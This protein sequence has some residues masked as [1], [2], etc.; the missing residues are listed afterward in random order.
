MS[1]LRS[2]GQ[3]AYLRALSFIKKRLTPRLASLS[4]EQCDKA[5]RA[6]DV[7]SLFCPRTVISATVG[8]DEH[9]SPGGMDLSERNVGIQLRQ[10]IGPS[11]RILIKEDIAL[12]T[13]GRERL[14]GDEAFVAYHG[15][16]CAGNFK[17]RSAQVHS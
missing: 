11:E 17:P 5:T 10:S 9:P 7:L 1:H 12:L 13:A 15:R 2:G 6:F 14:F 4:V 8:P 3:Q 16:F